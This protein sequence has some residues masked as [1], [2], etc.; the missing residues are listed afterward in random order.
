VGK[1]GDVGAT[2]VTDLL[3]AVHQRPPL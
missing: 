3:N 2:A 1:V